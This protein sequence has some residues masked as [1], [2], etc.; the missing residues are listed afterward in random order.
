MQGRR[1]PQPSGADR[2]SSQGRIPRGAAGARS[3]HAISSA[4][5]G[6]FERCAAPRAR[7]D[8]SREAAGGRRPPASGHGRG[9]TPGPVP[10][11][12]AKPPRAESTAGAARGRAGRRWPVGGTGPGGPPGGRRRGPGPL[13]SCRGGAVGIPPVFEDIS[14]ICCTPCSSTSSFI[15]DLLAIRAIVIAH[16]SRWRCH[17]GF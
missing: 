10:N 3:V 5:P 9:D 17:G 8:A 14:H 15:L 6:P 4:R 12:E 2:P 16:F 13:F 7:G 11:P 1:R